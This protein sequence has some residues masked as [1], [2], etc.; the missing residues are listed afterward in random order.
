VSSQGVR[1]LVGARCR[2]ESFD[3]FP[4]YSHRAP[5]GKWQRV[6]DGTTSSPMV[7]A[8]EALLALE[9]ALPPSVPDAVPA[10]APAVVDDT[11]K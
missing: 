10:P 8:F 1:R 7:D 5:G 11:A 9:A 3:T 4:G 2:N 6:V